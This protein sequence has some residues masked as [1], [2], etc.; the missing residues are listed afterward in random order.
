MRAPLLQSVRVGAPVANAWSL[1]DLKKHLEVETDEDDALI[2]QYAE[3]AQECLTG[4]GTIYQQSWVHTR[5][6]DYWP[7]FS[8]SPAL[9]V[10]P[11]QTVARV[12]Y[13]NTAGAE[14]LISPA[15]Y[16]LIPDV[17]G[18]RLCWADG[19]DLPRD[20]AQRPDAVRVEYIAGYGLLTADAPQR[21][22]Q[23]IRLLV[24]HWFRHREEVVIAAGAPQTLPK[25]V[26]YLMAPLQRIGVEAW[27]SVSIPA[28]VATGS[29]NPV[30]GSAVD[31][32]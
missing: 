8:R 19:Y 17:M 11:V 22:Q 30:L 31:V 13:I 12:T 23:A 9:R 6:R 3:T 29:A 20:V 32:E 1:S 2:T 15:A 25:A 18:G 21:V 4:P 24:G 27:D 26:E 16:Y 5:W 10:S 28:L 7:D 14:M